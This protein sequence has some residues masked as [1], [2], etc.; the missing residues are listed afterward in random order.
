MAKKGE[1]A[2]IVDGLDADGMPILVVVVTGAHVGIFKEQAT[3]L[4][5]GIKRLHR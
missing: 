4:L 3:D 1:E 5:P 2:I